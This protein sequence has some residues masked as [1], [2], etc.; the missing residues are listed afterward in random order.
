FT[1]KVIAITG[2]SGKTSVKEMVAA[3]LG[4][5]APTLATRGNL[6]NHIGV[7]LTLLSLEKL[8][9]FAVIEMGASG[10]GEIAYLCAIARPHI[11]MVNNVMPAHIE[12]FG[13]LEVIADT[14]SDIYNALPPSGV[15]VMNRDERWARKWRNKVACDR[16]W[17]LSLNDPDGEFHAAH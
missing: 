17:D 3:I 8:H 9:R 4:R 10:P 7:P 11:S 5:I 14:K 2:S 6:N 1:G 13:S 12:G 16:I 15:A